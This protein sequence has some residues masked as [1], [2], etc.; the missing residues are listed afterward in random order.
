MRRQRPRRA[1]RASPGGRQVEEQAFDEQRLVRVELGDGLA[2]V[3]ARVERGGRGAR[4][5]ARATSR[6]RL[7]ALAPGPGQRVAVHRLERGDALEQRIGAGAAVRALVPLLE[8]PE[9]RPL[10][11]F[12]IARGLEL[13]RRAAP[14]SSACA[15]SSSVRRSCSASCTSSACSRDGAAGAVDGARHGDER[16]AHRPEATVE[17]T[18]AVEPSA[19]EP[20]EQLGALGRDAARPE[21]GR[22]RRRRRGT[23]SRRA[24]SATGSSAA[25]GRRRR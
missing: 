16:V 3:A 25:A 23:R 15:A 8:P 1:S 5:T 19:G 18:G 14:T 10:R 13:G 17:R 7:S 11:A 4:V 21:R 22:D 2:G 6:S 12:G 9:L 20:G 24:G